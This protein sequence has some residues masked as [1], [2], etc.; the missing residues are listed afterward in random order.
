MNGQGRGDG[1]RWAWCRLDKTGHVLVRSEVLRGLK[2]H[3]EHDPAAAR[4]EALGNLGQGHARR[5]DAVDQEDL[6]AVLGAELVDADGAV[7]WR[8]LAQFHA[9]Q[10]ALDGLKR[11][12]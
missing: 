12:G 3:K 7:L 11:A 10:L 9:A 4:D 1:R 5:R 6:A 8:L 2:T